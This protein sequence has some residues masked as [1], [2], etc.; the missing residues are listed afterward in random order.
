VAGQGEV[1]DQV[2]NERSTAGDITLYKRR[3]RFESATSCEDSA[4]VDYVGDMRLK[5]MRA[6]VGMTVLPLSTTWKAPWD[7]GDLVTIV[8]NRYGRSYTSDA[9]ITAVDVTVDADGIEQVVP[10]MEAI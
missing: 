10:E 3:E 1:A 9:K 5:D 7:I 6:E 2:V 8:A 4:A